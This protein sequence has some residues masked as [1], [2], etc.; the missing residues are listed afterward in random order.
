MAINDL[1]AEFHTDQRDA[2]AAPSTAGLLLPPGYITAIDPTTGQVVAVP[3]ADTPACPAA[4]APAPAP[5]EAL[6]VQS[7][8]AAMETTL[9]KALRMAKERPA[10]LPAQAPE[11]QQGLHPVWGQI[12]VLGSISMLAASGS[13]WMLGAALHEAAP[14]L[15]EI[16]EV[17][18]WTLYLVIG[19]VAAVVA[20]RLALTTKTSSGG[21]RVTAL[22]HRE[23]HTHIGKQ[24]GGFWKGQVNNNIR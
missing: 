21:T 15:P 10:P 6:T 13:A 17:L 9:E 7:V 1:Y 5:V 2:D 3:V 14:A 24:T 11:P 22:V 20:V 16:P 12:V 18:R 19:I 8:Q 4:P 23:T